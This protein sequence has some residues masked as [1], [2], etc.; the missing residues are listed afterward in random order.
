MNS[1]AGRL[2]R[3]IFDLD[4]ARNRMPNDLLVHFFMIQGR[5][6]ESL[7]D[8]AKALTAYHNALEKCAGGHGTS[9]GGRQ[10]A[11]IA[12]SRRAQ[13]EIDRGLKVDPDESKLW[14]AKAE[15]LLRQGKWDEFDAV[16]KRI[17]SLAPNSLS[18]SLLQARRLMIQQS[19]LPEAA[20]VLRQA[21]ERAPR[22]E[23]AALQYASVRARM[24]QI[25]EALKE[26][27]SAATAARVGDRSSFRINRANLLLSLGRG[28]EARAV[29]VRDIA[30]LSVA[31]RPVIWNFLGQIDASQGD[32][33]GARNA[34]LEY[35]RLLPED[36][37]PRLVP[38]RP[39]DEQP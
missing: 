4:R 14:Y 24:G 18:L 35:A 22:S 17:S 31:D 37:R 29:L 28:R 15:I 9:S 27:E 8:R 12:R 6:Y 16:L 13:R 3:A 30:Q 32:L 11:A 10:P 36:P 25:D 7:G 20:Q 21:V 39:R 33:N 34:Y 5:S 2:T 23:A 19:K 26:L 38:P 1:R